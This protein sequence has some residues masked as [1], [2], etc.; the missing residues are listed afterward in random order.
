M[1]YNKYKVKKNLGKN[2]QKYLIK[3]KEYKYLDI[4]YEP[5]DYLMNY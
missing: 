1:D 4:T 5:K 3:Q 2:D